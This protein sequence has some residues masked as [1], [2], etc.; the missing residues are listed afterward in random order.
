MRWLALLGLTA[1]ALLVV[2]LRRRFAVVTVVGPSMLPTFAPGDRVLIRRAVVGELRR[3]QVV[4][5]EKPGDAGN[6]AGPA[7]RWPPSG[8]PLLIKRVAA[9]PGEPRPDDP[10][11][12]VPEGKLVVLGDNR[13]RSYDSRQL[14]YFPGERLIGVVLRAI[15]QVGSPDTGHS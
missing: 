11:S 15:G 6:W 1:P 7:P 13:A 14:G 8:H 2:A 9:V 5:I 3:G 10:G 12:S 4:V